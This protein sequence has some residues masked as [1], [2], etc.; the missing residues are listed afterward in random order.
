MPFR[1]CSERQTI[2]AFNEPII[3]NN[4]QSQLIAYA[5]RS[6]FFC[7]VKSLNWLEGAKGI[8]ILLTELMQPHPRAQIA[9]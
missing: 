9:L 8:L 3:F 5:G 2:G 1:A 4:C 7:C 6:G